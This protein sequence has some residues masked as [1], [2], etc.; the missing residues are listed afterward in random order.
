MSDPADP[1]DG[2]VLPAG[3]LLETRTS[4]SSLD[5]RDA[6]VLPAGVPLPVRTSSTADPRD[7]GTG[8]QP[9]QI[10]LTFDDGPH[11]AG[12]G[13]TNYTIDIATLLKSRNIVGAFF[14]Q[15]NVSH[16]CGCAAGKSVV[17]K[18]SD[19]GHV[20]AIHTGSD[21]D[22][23]SHTKRVTAPAYDVDGDKKPDGMNGLESDLIRAKAEI[24]KMIGGDAPEF[25]RAVGLERNEAVN[26]TYSRVGLK[27]IGVNVDS[28]DNEPPRPTSQVVV[29]TLDSG[30]NS[31]QHAI[32]AGATDLIVLFHDINS[33]TAASVST[34]IDAISAAVKAEGR[35]PEFTTSK[36]AVLDIFLK[37]K[38]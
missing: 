1:R 38:I 22:H 3:V 26:K 33:T 36:K 30:P 4:S 24:Q 13:A 11:A 17:K 15:T 32:A 29:H 6:G 21:G 19:M 5:P 8:Q 12:E 7:A 18:V 16:R 2:G 35:T 27:H 14:I 25:V 9:I 20:I 10:V 23:V 37:T 34:Y 28:K 31:V